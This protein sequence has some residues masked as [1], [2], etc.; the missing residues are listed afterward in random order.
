MPWKT[1]AERVVATLH[2]PWPISLTLALLFFGASAVI[3]LAVSSVL[4]TALEDKLAVRD[5]NSLVDYALGVQQVLL[6]SSPA[7]TDWARKAEERAQGSLSFDMRVMTSE[8]Q[9]LLETSDMEA[10]DRDFPPPAEAPASSMAAVKWKSEA[11]EAYMLTSAWVT[12][13]SAGAPRYRLQLALDLT[14]SEAIL[15]SYKQELLLVLGIA[16]L[17]A[18]AAAAA[19]VHASLRPL[20]DFTRAAQSVRADSLSVRLGAGRWPAELLGLGQAFDQML[21][22]LEEAFVRLSSYSS[23]MAHEFRTPMQNLIASTT[24]ALSRTRSIEEYQSLLDASL[25]EYERVSRMVDH[26]LFIARSENAETR[27]QRAWLSSEE[28]FDALLDFFGIAAEEAGVTLQVQ[29]VARIWADAGLFRQ[30]VSNL[31]SNALRHTPAHGVIRLGA[32]ND[33]DGSAIIV[34]EDSGQGIAAEH[35]P[36]L[37]DRFYR[38]D[39]GRARQTAG[40]GLGLAI[41]QTILRLH[42]GEVSVS[43][44]AGRGAKFFLR[45]PPASSGDPT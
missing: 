15:D 12:Q 21:A 7:G 18:A 16:L 30:A 34:V 20:R 38:A 32:R 13:G 11:G 36:R 35:L 43:S 31:L 41:V 24:V 39:Y 29:G 23:D 27:L 42:G 37:F 4:Y 45:F 19:V 25:Q 10:A 5:R 40:A 33:P 3:L 28:Q 44:E 2:G 8:G 9:T 26:M 22:R 6:E 17:A 1:K 14:E